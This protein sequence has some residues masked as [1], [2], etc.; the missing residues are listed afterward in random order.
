MRTSL[1]TLKAL[2][3]QLEKLG[4]H[5]VSTA[6]KCT[7]GEKFPLRTVEKAVELKNAGEE[8]TAFDQVIDRQEALQGI[9]PTLASA[10][11]TQQHS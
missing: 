8:W 1:C 3:M 6:H 11:V 2:W 9:H 4:E 10:H 5:P 7:I